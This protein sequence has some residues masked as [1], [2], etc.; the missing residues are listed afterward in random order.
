[1]ALFALGY[2]GLL[3]GLFP[4][5]VPYGLSFR[6][7]AADPGAQAFLLAG[8]LLLLP[9]TLGYTAYVYWVFRGKTNP[10]AAYH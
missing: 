9:L 1:V 8:T 5:L 7:A 6:E 2:T 4:Y 10:D 3:I